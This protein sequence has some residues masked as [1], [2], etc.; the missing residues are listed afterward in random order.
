MELL[1]D[2]NIDINKADE[3]GYTALMAAS[4]N[5]H[6]K[7]VQSLLAWAEVDCNKSNPLCSAAQNGHDRV[8]DL[9]LHR[10]QN[11]HRR[12][13][14]PVRRTP[15]RLSRRRQRWPGAWLSRSSGSTQ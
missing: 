12:Q 14:L 5:G 6:E 3:D 9:L 15:A 8:V 2:N 4:H 7:V 13:H 11:H 1:L 10:H